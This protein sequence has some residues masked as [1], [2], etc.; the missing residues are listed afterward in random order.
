MKKEIEQR[1]KM[2]NSPAVVQK[3]ESK[4]KELKEKMMKGLSEEEKKLIGDYLKEKKGE[5]KS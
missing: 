2:I 4:K 1:E 3:R 5:G